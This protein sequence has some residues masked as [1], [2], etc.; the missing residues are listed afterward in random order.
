MDVL[1]I[2]KSDHAELRRQIGVVIGAETKPK[3]LESYELLSGGLRLHLKLE[4]EY[5]YPE[6]G[7][8]LNGS[9]AGFLVR[10]QQN[11]KAI[12]KKMVGIE[13]G[14]R[15]SPVADLRDSLGQLA[16]AVRDHL[17]YEEAVMMPRL[18]EAMPTLDRE[19]LGTVFMDVKD[20]EH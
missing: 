9:S 7:V 20:A 3:L 1:Q 13:K 5:L 2:I 11:H 17:E 19:D 14:L 4:G 12:L 8:L 6:L 15:T 16:T 18:R 10:S